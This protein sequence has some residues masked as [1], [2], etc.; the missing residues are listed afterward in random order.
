MY[1]IQV[2]YWKDL[3][4][5]TAYFSMETLRQRNSFVAKNHKSI[6]ILKKDKGLENVLADTL[7]AIKSESTLSEFT[8][9]F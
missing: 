7:K 4:T 8:N 9:C 3:I 6:T 2:Q 1:V 5:I